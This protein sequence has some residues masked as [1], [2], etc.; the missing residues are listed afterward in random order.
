MST[1]SQKTKVVVILAP[2]LQETA[3]AT[4]LAYHYQ[5]EIIS[6]DSRQ[7]YQGLDIG[8]GRFGGV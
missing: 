3:L 4:K 6:A 5:G 7:V 8:S 2:L 1:K